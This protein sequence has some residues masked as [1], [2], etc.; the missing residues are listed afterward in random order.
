MTELVKSLPLLTPKEFVKWVA[1]DKPYYRE[2]VI[3]GLVKTSLYSVGD[4]N[5]YSYIDTEPVFRAIPKPEKK[6]LY[7]YICGLDIIFRTAR[8]LSVVIGVN[9]YE[10]APEYDIEYKEQ[11]ASN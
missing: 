7:A 2:K 3:Y 9:K 1:Q 6:K 11:N 4:A 5:Y 8:L 10:Y